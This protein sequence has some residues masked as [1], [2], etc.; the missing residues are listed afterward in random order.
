MT[1]QHASHGRKENASQK[2]ESC[3]CPG[4]ARNPSDT[5]TSIGKKHNKK[6]FQKMKMKPSLL[7]MRL[8]LMTSG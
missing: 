1:P 6:F 2:A 5:C 8:E 4:I 7:P 3:I